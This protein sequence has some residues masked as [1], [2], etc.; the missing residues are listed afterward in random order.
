MMANKLLFLTISLQLFLR[1]VSGFCEISRSTEDYED[2]N[3]RVTNI[4]PLTIDV[5]NMFTFGSGCIGHLTTYDVDTTPSSPN[6]MVSVTG[7]S[8]GTVPIAPDTITIQ[9]I[10]PSY[11]CYI[12]TIIRT[13][14]R[15]GSSMKSCFE[16]YINETSPPQNPCFL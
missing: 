15:G 16:V 2:P 3:G 6:T 7:G 12:F 9:T 13:V 14:N 4:S 10:G 1:L 5:T 11:D 8:T